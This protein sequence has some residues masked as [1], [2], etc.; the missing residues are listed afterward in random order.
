MREQIQA[1]AGDL[2]QE[3]AWFAEIL[4]TRFKLY[5]DQETAYRDVFAIPPPDLS[6]S[7][8]NYARFVYHYPLSFTERVAVVL[9]LAP[10]IRPQLLDVFFLKN[11]TFDR[12]FTEFGGVRH[13]PDGDF[14]PTGETLAFILAANDLEIR[15]ALQALFDRDH[16][17][18]RHHILRLLP[19]GED[20]SLLKAPLRLIGRI[21]GLVHHRSVLPPGFRSQVSCPPDRDP[22]RLGRSGVAS[23]YL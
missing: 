11:K 22:T 6:G 18:V 19:S 4:D 9:G 23:R 12:R 13:G 10:H 17:F 7:D 8:S 15:F 21:P 1:N 3:L 5:F 2:E 16:F 14:V 20:E